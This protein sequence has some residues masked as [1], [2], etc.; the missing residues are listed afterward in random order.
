M[1]NV[2]QT[3]TDS[4]YTI[5]K[6]LWKSEKKMTLADV[7]RELDGNDWTAST[8]STFLQRL[9]KKEVIACDKKG[10]TNLYY[11]LLKQS[12]YDL[13]ETENFLSKIYK[14]SVKNLVAALYENKKLSNEDVSD[15]K[16][17][18]ELE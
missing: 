16:K 10:K 11:P 6:I 18:F 12:E 1:S 8:V 7:V 3:I 2:K 13:R 4:E 9:L 14:G 17:M 5:M 15:L